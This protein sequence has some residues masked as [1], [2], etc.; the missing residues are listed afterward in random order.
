VWRKKYLEGRDVYN[1]F[2]IIHVE[3]DIRR[4]VGYK[5]N[6]RMCENVW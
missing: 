2:R 3:L 4:R 1:R 5:K 6:S